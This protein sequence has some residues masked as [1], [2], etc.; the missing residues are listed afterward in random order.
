[1]IGRAVYHELSTRPSYAGI[2]GARLMKSPLPPI[3][4]FPVALRR[5]GDDLHGYPGAR[6]GG[7]KGIGKPGNAGQG[8]VIDNQDFARY[9]CSSSCDWRSDKQYSAQPGCSSDDCDFGRG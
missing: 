1:M 6:S 8:I 5:H 2:D 4:E 9:R 3:G 7:A